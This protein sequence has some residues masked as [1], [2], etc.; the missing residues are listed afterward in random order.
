MKQGMCI[1]ALLALLLTAPV[2]AAKDSPPRPD[3]RLIHADS[4]YLRSHADNPV[5][6]YP[7]GQ[8]ALDRARAEN[9]PIIVSVGYAACHWCH[10]MED[11]SFMNDAIAAQMN[12]DFV[13]IKIDRES[14][15]DLDEQFMLATQLLS[16]G[17]GWPNTVFLTP[18]GDPFYAGTYF[19]PDAFAS[20]LQSVAQLWSQEP[21]LLQTEAAKVS[22]AIGAYLTR[23]ADAQEITPE[24][25][26]Q[27]TDGIYGAL[28]D[29]NGG[30]GT[31]PKFPRES[32]FLFL[33]DHAE[34]TGDARALAAV[35]DMLDGMIK[36]GIHDHVGGGFHR[37]AV[38]PEWHVPHFEKMLYNQALT[39]R[40]LVRAWEMTGHS[41]YRRAAERTFDYV[42][43]E[44]RDPKGGFYA[45]QDADSL[46]AEGEKVEGAFY[47][48]TPEQLAVLGADAAMI[49]DLFQV[50]THGDLDGANVLHLSD[51]PGAIAAGLDLG[52]DA[53]VARLDA[54][55]DTLRRERETRPAPFLDRKIVVAW[56]AMMIQT[57]AEAGGR[58]DRPDYAQ[59]AQEAAQF[60]LTDLRD[61]AGLHR[62]SFDGK[63]GIPGQL[64]D[65]AGLGLALIALHDAADTDADRARWLAAAHWTADQVSTRFG[66]GTHGF[67]MTKA[68]EGLTQIVPVDDTEI[69]SGNALALGL[70]SRL[71]QRSEAPETQRR[72]VELASAL[73]GHAADALEQR[74][75]LM[76]ALQD[77]QTGETGPVRFAAN[78]KVRVEVHH[79]PGSAAARFAVW[80][81]DGWHIN[82]H[83]PL[84]DYFIPTEVTFA[85]PAG[86]EVRYPPAVRKAL[87]F[88]GDD[89]ALYENRVDIVAQRPAASGAAQRITLT[90][91]AC[92]DEICLQPENL[93]FTLW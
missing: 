4:P 10:V 40:L 3:S 11:E 90:L 25:I 5:D 31:A 46:N 66:D 92:N 8:E 83:E 74:G 22:A 79:V 18:Q 39:G 45:A 77:L 21:A 33:L 13:S 19:P 56:N 52:P 2:V 59:A 15:P 53:F 78:G 85:D 55:L 68:A 47:L 91:Q 6:W 87:E 89:L 80:I 24:L 12:R 41:R 57:L 72:A 30:I 65:Y 82:A 48:W 63:V 93:Q 50:D 20:I 44:M 38:D 81:T 1:P 35:T 64:A 69:P 76:K 54:A 49:A 16:G 34:R 75:Y 32:L 61:D 26:G 88:N 43:R 14:R 51:L 60:I 36:G 70:V 23:K 28:D 17:G 86:W 73:S 9:R 84:D 71:V 62:V 29:F 58:L 42:L 27:L 67:T 7:W 37:Y